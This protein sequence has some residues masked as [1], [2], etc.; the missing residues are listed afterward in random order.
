MLG[1]TGAYEIYIIGPQ[2]NNAKILEQIAGKL[3]F[4]N[5]LLCLTFSA[6]VNIRIVKASIE[7]NLELSILI[8]VYK[9][10]R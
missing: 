8:R 4:L 5:P 6:T 2:R 3:L 9:R 10:K 1:C 7:S